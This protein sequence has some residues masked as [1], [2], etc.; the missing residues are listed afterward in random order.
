M[1]VCN[2]FHLSYCTNIHPGSDWDTTLQSLKKYIPNIKHKISPA[3]SFGIGLRL[4][5][6]AS[7][8]LNQGTNLVDFRNWLA[9]NDCY[10][11]TMNGFP[12]G[13]FHGESVK[14]K[15]HEPD[16][17][18]PKRLDYTRRLFDQLAFLLSDQMEGGISSSPLSYKHWHTTD[19]KVRSVMKRAAENLALLAQF[20]MEM[21]EQTGHYMHLDL[22]PEPDG[23]LE[24][25]A[26]VVHF[27]ENYLLPIGSELL[28]SRMPISRQQA[29][30][31][32]LKYICVCY[33]ICHFS[34]AY[35]EPE[36]SFKIWEEFGIRVGKIQ[37]SA[38][39]KILSTNDPEHIWESLSH[40]DEP[41]YLHQVTQLKDNQVFTYSDLPEVLRQKP[42]FEELR[43]HF[44]V[45][46]FLD[47]FE[48][49]YSTQDHI[50]KVLAYIQ[51]HPVTSHLE[52][53]TSTW[54]VLP[55]SLK[56]AIDDSIVRELEWVLK[57]LLP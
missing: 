18:D 37:I 44:H 25:T 31:L 12:Y 46:I 34:L 32:L 36:H 35:E 30:E 15:V 27:F 20:L 52:I 33:D 4:S 51:R 50:L 54:E 57:E 21:E 39:L 38:A 40:F 13:N 8:E 42:G 29:D 7:E 43:A 28:C 17:T 41:T 26:D 16:W 49:L 14:D 11:Y 10:V 5:N 9:K 23:L 19:D 2:R 3:S 22:E 45:P 53:E 47:S 6:K 55:Q 24:N 56:T 48:N 1:L